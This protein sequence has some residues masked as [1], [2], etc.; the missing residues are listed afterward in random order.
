MVEV[1]RERTG[2]RDEKISL[3]HRDWGLACQATDLDFLLLEYTTH[4]GRPVLAALIEYKMRNNLIPPN[5][6]TGQ[7]SALIRF[8]DIDNLPF[9]VVI[10]REDCSE[11]S[12]IPCNGSA[13]YWLQKECRMSEFEY[14]T[15]LYHLRGEKNIPQDVIE[16]L[17]R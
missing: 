4:H 10:Y 1:A 6:N 11:F 15:F 12:V 2:W 3:R 13:I 8:C 17:K 5:L 7:Y 14:V 9:F 16:K